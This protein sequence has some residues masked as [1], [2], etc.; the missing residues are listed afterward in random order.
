MSIISYNNTRNNTYIPKYIRYIDIHN[1]IPVSVFKLDNINLIDNIKAHF[2]SF[3]TIKNNYYAFDGASF[4]KLHS[5]DWTKYINKNVNM[6]FS[7]NEKGENLG[8]DFN[9]MVGYGEYN[10]YRV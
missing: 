6:R 10:Y 8:S 5:F 9:F 4:S 3:V 7:L 1:K 2:V